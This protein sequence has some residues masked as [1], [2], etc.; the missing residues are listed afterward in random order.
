MMHFLPGGKLPNHMDQRLLFSLISK[1]RKKFGHSWTNLRIVTRRQMQSHRNRLRGLLKVVPI[2][3]MWIEIFDFPPSL[4]V[5]SLFWSWAVC[6]IATHSPVDYPDHFINMA[7]ATILDWIRD[8]Q[9]LWYSGSFN[10][11]WCHANSPLQNY[12][13]LGGLSTISWPKALLIIS[14][15]HFIISISYNT[16]FSL[17]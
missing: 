17:V 1:T 6:L 15:R 2:A 3:G 16:D 13:G 9:D 10:W 5:P 7:L 12:Q 8:H 4:R 14:S 11:I